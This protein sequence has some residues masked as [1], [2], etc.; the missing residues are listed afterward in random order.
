MAEK[1]PPIE[2][3]GARAAEAVGAGRDEMNLA[4]FPLTLLAD[5]V[6]GE[7]KTLCYA[8]RPGTLIVTGSDAFGLPTAA[9]ADVII[10]LIQ[11]TRLRN[12]FAD[13][14]VP[15]TRYEL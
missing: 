7:V 5:R 8:S 9:D 15:F 1:T 13:P 10:G 6:P 2:D 3:P 11:L 12:E 14:K 4:E